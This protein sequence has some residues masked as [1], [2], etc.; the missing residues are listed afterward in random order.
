MIW[1]S[2]Y[3]I[4]IKGKITGEIWGLLCDLI[5]WLELCFVFHDDIIKWEHFPCY[6]TFAR[7]I[8][9]F[10]SQ[11]PVTR[12]FDVF[13][14]LHLIKHLSKHSRRWWF[15]MPSCS[16]WHHCNVIVLIYAIPWDTVLD[17]MVKPI[18]NCGSLS[19][20]SAVNLALAGFPLTNILGENMPS[21]S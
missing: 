10:P 15:E 2:F 4:L 1:C 12:S 20:F 5:V 16:L 8:G 3:Q 13:C 14:D 6:W 7:G 11:R 9:E 18:F 21:H 17:H 19:L